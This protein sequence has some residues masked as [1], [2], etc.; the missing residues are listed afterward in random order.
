MLVIDRRDRR[1][2]L[3]IGVPNPALFVAYRC[4]ERCLGSDVPDA[5]ELVV[6]RLAVFQAVLRG[7]G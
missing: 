4:V 2:Q 5:S 1:Q 6:G 3:F 7:R